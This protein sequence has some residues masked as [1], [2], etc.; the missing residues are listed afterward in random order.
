M[1]DGIENSLA[2]H[3]GFEP[4]PSAQQ[5]GTLP[6]DHSAA[7]FTVKHSKTHVLKLGYYRG[8]LVDFVLFF[9]GVSFVSVGGV[10]TLRGL[11]LDHS[12]EIADFLT[13]DFYQN[14]Y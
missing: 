1:K 7:L 5:A 2:P 13:Q 14:S 11:F 6:L 3:P 9:V 4:P 8:F 12:W 10:V